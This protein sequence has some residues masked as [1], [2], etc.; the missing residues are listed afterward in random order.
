MLPGYDGCCLQ[1]SVIT[2]VNL[3]RWRWRRSEDKILEAVDTM[4]LPDKTLWISHRGESC[5]APENTIS[6]FR[7]ARERGTDG[8]ECDV[9]LSTDGRVYIYHDGKTLRMSDGNLDLDAGVTWEELQKLTLADSHPEFAPERVALFAEAAAE[10]GEN[11]LFFVELKGADLA[12]VPAL[13]EEVLRSGLT[14]EQCIFIAFDEKMIVEIKKAMPEYIALWLMNIGTWENM[15]D[16]IA[17]LREMG[18]DG[19][20]TNFYDIKPELKEQV[21]Q[22]HDAGFGVGFWTV[23][24]PALARHLVECGVDYITSNCAAAIRKIVEH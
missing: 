2:W 4:K 11:R 5:D 7:L 8:S 9:R 6:A 12:L 22:L 16:L 3:L 1:N 17:K 15:G 14:P 21:R 13:K 10:L 18:I 19:I 23:D 20:D 24:N